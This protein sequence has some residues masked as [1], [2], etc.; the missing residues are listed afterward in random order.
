VRTGTW[1]RRE[2][3]IEFS[4]AIARKPPFLMEKALYSREKDQS[5]LIRQ[6]VFFRERN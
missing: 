3:A 4:I 5:K 6:N 2:K 1:V